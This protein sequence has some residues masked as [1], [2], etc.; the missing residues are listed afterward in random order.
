MRLL[1]TVFFATILLSGWSF[2][3]VHPAAG[4]SG[5]GSDD[6]ASLT[7]HPGYVN[8]SDVESWFD[9]DASIQVDI[10]GSLL[11]LVA[12]STKE[13]DADFSKM[14]DGLQ[15]IQVRG[16]PMT[17]L[18]ADAIGQRVD[19]LAAEL[20]SQGWKRVLYVRDGAEVARVYLRPDST[21][22]GSNGE[23]SRIAGL[24]VLAVDPADETVLVNVV[25]PMEPE[26]IQKL[27]ANL[28]VESL[29]QVKQ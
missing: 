20:E 11:H 5:T 9:T 12:Q 27:G 19:R 1:R 10:R 25:G 24:T 17:G 8:L 26:Q 22:T 15:A 29:R 3:A 23:G 2:P 21:A 18:D 13:S 16:Y 28:N 4:Q 14:V 7:S 6:A